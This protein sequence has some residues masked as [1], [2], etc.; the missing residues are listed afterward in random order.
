MKQKKIRTIFQARKV[1]H[2]FYSLYKKKKKS[3]SDFDKKNIESDIL[4]LQ[5]AINNND[6]KE[7]NNFAT[8]LH[9]YSDTCL[10]KSLFE[11]F[12]D[13]IFAIIFA[14]VVALVIRQMWFESHNIPTGS[15]RPTLKEKDLLIVSKTR[16]SIN[17]VLRTGHFYFDPSLVKRGSTVIF[18]ASNLD[19][20]DP[21]TMYFW[22]FPGTKQ[23]I[24]RLIAKPN[25]ILYFYGGKLYGIDENGNEITDFYSPYISQ[26]EHIPF[27]RF[28]GKQVYPSSSHQGILSPILLYQTNIAVARLSL[29]N[30]GLA[31]GQ[32]FPFSKTKQNFSDYFDIWGFKNY[33]MARILTKDEAKGLTNQDYPYFLELMHHP[34]VNPVQIMK[35]S[36]G[37]LRPHLTY[38]RSYMP[39]TNEHMKKIFENIYTTRFVVKNEKAVKYFYQSNKFNNNLPI[40]KNVKNGTYE[41]D[42]GKALSINW[43][44]ITSQVKN[45]N[46]LTQ[47]SPELAQTLFNLG[48][49]FDNIFSP[50]Q[51]D[52]FPNRY[53]YFLNGDFYLMGSKIIDKDDPVLINFTKNEKNCTTAFIDNGPPFKSDGSLDKEFIKKYGMHIPEDMYYVLGDN[54]AASGD[55]R[56]FGFVPKDNLRGCASFIFWPPGKRWGALFQPPSSFFVFPNIFICSAAT[57]ILLISYWIIHNIR[58]KPIVFK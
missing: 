14:L 3:L 24:K 56:E 32:L 38:T 55:S 9:K 6:K 18:S 4:K 43:T 2:H 21:N 40:L 44:G 25:D 46:A 22:I 53:G 49:D 58:K 34:S 20:A 8:D 47:Y 45:T 7:I 26:I 57:I 23:F 33:A 42:K 13:F 19:V 10:K 54:H 51:S 11:R 39:L 41:F 30:Y 35:D 29:N 5:D 1:L 17:T 36:Y 37:L 27:I 16:F 15:M 52:I 28:E 12:I 31:N 50:S 48:I